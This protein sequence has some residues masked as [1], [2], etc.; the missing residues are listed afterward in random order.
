MAVGKIRSNR[1][2]RDTVVS[3]A[4]FII[5]RTLDSVSSGGI[6]RRN[7]NGAVNL[8]QYPGGFRKTLVNNHGSIG[9][10]Q[11]LAEWSMACAI[12]KGR[13]TAVGALSVGTGAVVT[14]C[15]GRSAACR[16]RRWQTGL[17]RD[18]AGKVRRRHGQ[19]DDD[20]DSSDEIVVCVY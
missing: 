15:G 16:L 4:E 14:G 7:K 3:F 20:Q 12:A 19:I 11:P 6:L 18:G 10:L 13:I 8:R 17:N 5:I 1:V 2:L 9:E